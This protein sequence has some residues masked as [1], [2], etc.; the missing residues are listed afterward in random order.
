M[1]R[2]THVD[3]LEA[4]WQVEDGAA[5]CEAVKQLAAAMALT[6]ESYREQDEDPPPLLST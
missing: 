3:G 6:G 2:L 4:L 5:Q 1:L